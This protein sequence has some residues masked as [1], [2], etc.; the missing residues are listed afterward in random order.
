LAPGGRA[1]SDAANENLPQRPGLAQ[2]VREISILQT[3]DNAAAE[4]SG[5]AKYSHASARHDTKLILPP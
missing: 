5:I 2:R 1:L 4:K 3:A